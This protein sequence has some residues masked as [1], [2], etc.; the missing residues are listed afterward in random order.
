MIP[1]AEARQLLC[2]LL[3]EEYVH[4]QVRGASATVLPLCH[5]SAPLPL[6]CP[7]TTVLSSAVAAQQ[8]GLVVWQGCSF[9]GPG[10]PQ[11]AIRTCPFGAMT[12][13]PPLLGG[14]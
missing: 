12:A 11:L 2:R 10:N 9:H 6:F 4:L 8:Q 13:P 14:E 3:L 7:S 5:C 1:L